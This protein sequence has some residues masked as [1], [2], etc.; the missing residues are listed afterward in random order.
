MEEYHQN[1]KYEEL[2]RDMY[3]DI[4]WIR[5]DTERRNGVMDEHIANSDRYRSL[6]DGN[7]AWRHIF[8]VAIGVLAVGIWYVVTC[9]MK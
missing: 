1:C 4:K 5:M 9:H 7:T 3:A 6:V 2:I 8:K